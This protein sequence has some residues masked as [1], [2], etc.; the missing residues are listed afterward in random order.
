[1]NLS[2]RSQA[3][4]QAQKFLGYKPCYLDTET[5]GT[6]AKD[7]ILEIAIIDH[8]GQVLLDTLVKPVGTIHPEAQAVHGIDQ[9]SVLDAPR[10][11]E[12]WP[13]VEVILS[14]RWVGI[15]NADFDLRLFQQS[16]S[17]N[18][19]TWNPP[20]GMQTFCVM[21]L[22]AQFYGQWDSRRGSYRWHS[23]DAAGKQCRIP[24]PNS[25]RAGEDVLLTRAILEHIA[26]QPAS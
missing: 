10:W 2:P 13:E 1:M 20:L 21:K 3:I 16:H 9:A 5:T 6:G 19:L 12:V 4:L 8:D 26:R 17:L 18:W 15:Y 7:N 22:Y 23:L 11:N 25:H 14:N 24:L